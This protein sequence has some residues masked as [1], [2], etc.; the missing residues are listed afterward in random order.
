MAE[1]SRP[2]ALIGSLRNE[3]PFFPV[4][5]FCSGNVRWTFRAHYPILIIS[6]DKESPS[7]IARTATGPANG[8]TPEGLTTHLLN[9]GIQGYIR[10][11]QVC[12]RAALG[13]TW[14]RLS[15]GSQ[16]WQG[17]KHRA[18]IHRI[19]SVIL[20]VCSSRFAYN[21]TTATP[22]DTRRK[23]CGPIGS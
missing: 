8:Y 5:T 3:R 7:P 21:R 15:V 13:A 19:Q 6:R 18:V 17:I 11:L 22:F 12:P 14:R 9:S 1:W 4:A 10:Q 2:Q 16:A 23:R 20:G